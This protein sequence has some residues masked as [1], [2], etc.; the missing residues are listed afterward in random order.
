MGIS[1]F[2]LPIL[3][4]YNDVIVSITTYGTHKTLYNFTLDLHDILLL[5]S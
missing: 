1:T 3:L 2:S 4:I 5:I